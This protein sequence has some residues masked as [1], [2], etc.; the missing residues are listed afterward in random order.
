MFRIPY[1]APPFNPGQQL[2]DLGT[3]G[4]ASHLG[5]LAVQ[6]RTYPTTYNV[7]VYGM[8]AVMP[9]QVIGP[10]APVTANDY[11]HPNTLANLEI[12]GLFKSPIPPRN[13]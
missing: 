1:Y 6:P 2:V 13:G 12:A 8:A 9:R 10:S 4:P 11:S 5:L 3:G 7:G